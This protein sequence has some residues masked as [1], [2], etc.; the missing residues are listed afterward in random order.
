MRWVR[1][2]A[3]ASVMINIAV[4]V[5]SRAGFRRGRDAAQPGDMRAIGRLHHRAAAMTLIGITV[6]T[7]RMQMV[8]RGCGRKSTW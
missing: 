6:E 7:S 8:G 2:I 5:C 1:L 4:C 3:T